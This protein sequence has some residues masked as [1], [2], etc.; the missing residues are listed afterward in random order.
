MPAD[1][2]VTPRKRRPRPKITRKPITKGVGPVASGK[3]YAAARRDAAA[4]SNSTASS[5]A[6]VS[7]SGTAKIE[8][9]SVL[10]QANDAVE[11][12]I[13]KVVPGGKSGGGFGAARKKHEKRA[14]TAPNGAA[15]LG[16]AI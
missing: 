3:Q 2:S 8:S 4:R 15:A 9:R 10:Q 13:G 16:P 14:R 11:G 12:A 6:G 5:F 1:F 7:G